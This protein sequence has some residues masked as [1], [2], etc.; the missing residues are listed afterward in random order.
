ME[1]LRHL[2]LKE[3]L[4]S[5][6]VLACGTPHRESLQGDR[7][8]IEGSSTVF[9]I[10]QVLAEKF[11]EVENRN[12]ERKGMV[13]VG[14]SGTGG[15]FQKFCH[16]SEDRDVALIGASRPITQKEK[17]VCE[18]R[19]VDYREIPIAID[20]IAVVVNLNN[21]WVKNLTFEELKKI[22]EP[23]AQEKI[24]R[25]SQIRD[26]WP[27]TPLR[28][29][30]PG[31]ASGTF[32]YFTERV[33]GKAGESRGDYNASEND[34]TLVIG[35]EGDINGLAYFGFPYAVNNKDKLKIV[36]LDEGNGPVIPDESTIRK[37][38]YPLSRPLFFYVNTERLRKNP[39]VGR[40]LTYFFEN[41]EMIVIEAGYIPL[42]PE[43]YRQ[44]FEAIQKQ[45]IMPGEIT[46]P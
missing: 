17:R 11:D 4:L 7:F 30:G 13:V 24:T 39:A 38:Q 40:L 22:W 43:S 8:I 34:N 27:D 26:G 44:S 29:Y 6:A 20:G 9:L 28:L 16:P 46:R 5:A 18:E 42:Q 25:W 10:S 14:V 41:T 3:A 36:P 12:G 32:D 31:T 33:N 2:P 45:G 19:G 1:L 21:T 23:A 37:G 35:V 15:G